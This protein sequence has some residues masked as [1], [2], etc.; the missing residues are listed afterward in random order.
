MVA[1]CCSR[2]YYKENGRQFGNCLACPVPMATGG[3]LATAS[4][5]VKP[6]QV[7]RI[8]LQAHQ[9]IIHARLAR[10]AQLEARQIQA[11]LRDTTARM[12]I[13]SAPVPWAPT[14][15]PGH[16]LYLVV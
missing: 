5:P 13:L 11:A 4:L 14:R 15:L 8:V 10:I 2:G 12:H 3:R 9:L 1:A 7:A 6:A 16:I